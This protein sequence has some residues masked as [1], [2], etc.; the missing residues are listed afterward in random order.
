[1]R[2][3]TR[4]RRKRKPLHSGAGRGAGLFGVGSLLSVGSVGGILSVLSI[5]S[6]GSILSIG[7]AGSILSIRS[8][9]SILSI[10]STGSILCIGSAG[11]ILRN[12]RPQ[13]GRYRR[14]VKRPSVLPSGFS[15][16]GGGSRGGPSLDR[17]TPL[18]W[19]P[20]PPL[21]H[22]PRV[23]YSGAPV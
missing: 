1:M 17:Q 19:R 20:R 21:A 11:G 6:A 16:R 15:G 10:G 18:L 12:R 5:G 7:S 8:A 13:E 9:G 22:P 23:R 14:T 4:S 3:A 2:K